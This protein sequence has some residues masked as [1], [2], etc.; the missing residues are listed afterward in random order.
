M[1]VITGWLFPALPLGRVAA[2]RTVVYLFVPVDVLLTSSWVA[3]H[4]DTPQSLYLPLTIGRLL[5]HPAPTHALVVSV[6]A[7]LLACSVAAATGRCPRALGTAVF[8]L[9]AEWMLIAMSYGKVDHDRFAFLVALAALP[10][11]GRARRGDLTPSAAAGWALRVTQIAVVATYFLASW[12]KLRFGGPE[13]LTGATLARAV[14][15]R[16]T[17]LSDWTLHVRPLLVACQFA[18]VGFELSSPAILFVRSDRSRYAMVAA[19]YA[20]HLMTFAAV[21]IVFLPHC[22]A[23]LAFLPLERIRRRTFA[24]MA[25]ARSGLRR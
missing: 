15:R 12:A 9:Y 14:L 18:I 8:L 7:A 25:V 20:F 4:K 2:F 11:V 6:M 17:V 5:H 10:T 21:T 16:G 13:W 24:G 23:M 1:R 22:V 19:L 3:R